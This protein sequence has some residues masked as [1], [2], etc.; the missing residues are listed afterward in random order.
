MRLPVFSFFLLVMVTSLAIAQPRWRTLANSPSSGSRHDDV[1][2]INHNIG[3]VVNGARQV[4]KT[5]NGGASWQLKFTAAGYLRSV[6]FAD[7]LLGWAGSLDSTTVLYR[8]TD[9]GDTWSLVTNLP[10]LRPAGICGIW[11]VN[12]NVMYGSG[13]YNGKPRVIKTTDGGASWTT[14]DLSS[15]ATCLV[16]CYFFNEDSGFVV[17]SKGPGPYRNDSAAVFFTSNGGATWSSRFVGSQANELSWKISFPTPTVGF[18]SIERFAT[19]VVSYFRTTDRGQSWHERQFINN[20]D[21]QGI[22]FI[23]QTVGWIGGWT[24]ATYETTNGG[25]S[26]HLAG[27][28][29]NVNRIRFLSDTLGYAVGTRVYKYSRD[30]TTSVDGFDAEITQ[31]SSLEQNFPN[32]FN[33]STTIRFELHHSGF[34]SIKVFNLLGEQVATLVNN[35]MRAGKYETV[36]DGGGLP[37]GVSSTG[38]YASGVYFYRLELLSKDDRLVRKS[39]ETKRLVLIR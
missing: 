1:F 28:G 6:G 7:S 24:G 35:E 23:N 25:A 18:I 11:V 3:W 16:D 14:I 15:I 32:P 20:Y 12:R 22:G 5:T 8:T 17:G 30:S 37:S 10:T 13:R 26:W 27:F 33:P 21:A 34:V 9:G 4:F 39:S 29:T 2:F 38:G 31:V 36:F 19:G